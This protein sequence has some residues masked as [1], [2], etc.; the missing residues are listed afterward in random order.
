MSCPQLSILTAAE[1]IKALGA[2]V[3]ATTTEKI[4]H[5]RAIQDLTV[6]LAGQRTPEAPPAP[7]VVVPSP[8]V[9][10]APPPRVATTL[11]D[12]TAPN[13][14]RNMP[15]VHQHQTC[16]NNPFNILTNNDDDDDT[17]MASNCSPR[18]PLP[19]LP[20]SELHVHLPTNL[21]RHQLAIQPKNLQ[22]TNPLSSP[23]TSPPP[24]VLASPTHIQAT[25]PTAPH[26]RIHDLH[27]TP[28][29]N[30]TKPPTCTKQQSYSIPI[31]EPDDDRDEML[32]T[33]SSTRP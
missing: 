26:I 1:L 32:T 18:T 9:P 24:R 29:E 22:T 15:L 8:R 10:N 27:P 7:R 14:I 6:I 11:N 28:A 4:K 33:R 20:T 25:A 16:N 21:P 17:M 31:V 12:I 13:I 5:I 3:P 19:S 23:P 2:A 30:P